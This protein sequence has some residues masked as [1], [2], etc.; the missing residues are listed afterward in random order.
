MESETA[1]MALIR[2]A[3]GLY[4]QAFDARGGRKVHLRSRRIAV[5]LLASATSTFRVFNRTFSLVGNWPLDAPTE[6]E[7]FELYLAADEITNAHD[8]VYTAL[9]WLGCPAR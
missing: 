9:E 6:G 4:K 5:L 2:A 3:R 8:H 7:A 1:Q